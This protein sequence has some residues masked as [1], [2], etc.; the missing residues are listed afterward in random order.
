MTPPFSLD[1]LPADLRYQ[2]LT[3]ATGK[4]HLTRIARRALDLAKTGQDSPDALVCFAREL[5]LAAWLCDPLDQ[6]AA[7]TVLQFEKHAPTL[8]EATI[9][10]LS[11]VCSM[12]PGAAL[13][14]RARRLEAEADA[15]GLV[16]CLAAALAASPSDSLI[17]RALYR[18]ACASGDF[19]T[20]HK[21]IGDFSRHDVLAPIL[22]ALRAETCFLEGEFEN[23]HRYYENAEQFVPGFFLD[24]AGE[25]LVQTG[26]ISQGLSLMRAALDRSPWKI[27]RA[28]RLYDLE[29]GIYRQTAPIDAKVAILLYSYNNPEKL[30]E[31]LES[32][33]ACDLTVPARAAIYVLV[34]G[35]SDAT[36]A[37]AQK[38][39][40]NFGP[41]LQSVSLPVN[42]GAAPARNWLMSLDG[43]A[44]SEWIA[45]LDDDVCLPRDWLGRFGAAMRAYPEAGLFGCRVL[46][47]KN[48][49]NLQQ[50]DLNFLPARDGELLFS[51]PDS[52]C[53]TFDL[54]QFSY[55]R[56]CA[57][58]TGCCHIFKKESLLRCGEFDIRFSPTQY[59][60]LD[61]DI[62]MN[63]L[64][65]QIVYQ[66]H[67]A[68][69]HKN[70]SG[71]LMKRSNLESANA[72]A[73]MYKLKSK[74][75]SAEISGI[76]KK[77][78]VDLEEDFIGKM[79]IN[80]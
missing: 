26:K 60:D 18:H 72:A 35:R 13:P 9:K 36:E 41:M 53:E 56:P 20:A 10:S 3:D 48:P 1:M 42:V 73:N 30:D 47:F 12:T 43:A 46:D 34:N 70:K 6:A 45:Y 8:P 79:N 78:A 80:K 59:D 55:L 58:V 49:A 68:V 61:H 33:H 39:K 54:Q 52:H 22:A 15:A 64:H 76:Q 37:V 32:L 67:L 19:S 74:Y 27:N 24:S 5:S 65:M 16:K 4:H 38:W 11:A 17:A 14:P 29:T 31:T 71:K 50:T 77:M 40:T 23:A 21:L 57:S 63:L 51:L 25:S 69:A 62:R 28:L 66:G 7:A 44:S 75:S 2:L